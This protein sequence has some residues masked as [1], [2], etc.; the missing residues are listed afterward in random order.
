MI[1]NELA[2]KEQAK[3]DEV[4]C[5]NSDCQWHNNLYEQNCQ[6]EYNSGS[7]YILDC[8]EYKPEKCEN[9]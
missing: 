4:N 5:V 2:I 6:A 9:S 7:P 8:A 1:E 3:I